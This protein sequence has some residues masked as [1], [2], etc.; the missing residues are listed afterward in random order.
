MKRANELA[1]AP[2]RD[3]DAGLARLWEVM[4]DCIDRGLAGRRA[5]CPAASRCA[6]ARRGI[7]QRA[8][9]RARAEPDRAAH[10]QRLDRRPTPWR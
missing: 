9:R 10:D 3:L 5:S 2:A 1:P 8:A 4:A 6:A 7:H